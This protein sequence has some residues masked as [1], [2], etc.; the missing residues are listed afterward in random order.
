MRDQQTACSCGAPIL[1]PRGPTPEE[2]RWMRRLEKV[3]KDAPPGIGL[4]T[5]GDDS[6]TVYRKTDAQAVGIEHVWDGG[7]S[8]HG[9]DL[10]TVHSAVSI[11]GVSG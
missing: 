10:G 6:L 3:L 7:S 9:L 11:E 2:S 8:R 5:I 1:T 4:L